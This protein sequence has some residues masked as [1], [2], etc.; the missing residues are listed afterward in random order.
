MT[1]LNPCRCGNRPEL[2]ALTKPGMVRI[3]CVLGKCDEIVCGVAHVA[4]SAW[5][6]M[7]PLPSP[8]VTEI[9][10]VIPLRW[11]DDEVTEPVTRRP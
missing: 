4:I 1:E 3:S 7:N 2:T 5:N 9:E 11:D 8:E 10:C 6:N